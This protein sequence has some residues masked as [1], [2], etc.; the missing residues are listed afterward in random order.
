V[1]EQGKRDRARI[2]ALEKKDRQS[3]K[4]SAIGAA[5]TARRIT[6]PEAKQ[7]AG[8]P[9]SFVR[10]FLEMRPKAIVVSEGDE[11]VPGAAPRSANGLPPDVE[12]QIS[13]ALSAVPE[14]ARAGAREKM[15]AEHNKRL[16]AGLNGAGRF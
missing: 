7:L 2:D 14:A 1:L 6:R 16:T 9:L 8:K 4:T 15:V 5:L 3:T 10:S 11:L 13:E 12:R